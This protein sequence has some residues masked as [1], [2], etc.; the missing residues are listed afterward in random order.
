LLIDE[1]ATPHWLEKFSLFYGN[2]KFFAMFYTKLPLDTIL[3]KLS[4][5]LTMKLCLFTFILILSPNQLLRLSS[6]LVI[7][8]IPSK[9]S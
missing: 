5:A 8:D 9:I 7:G 6:G 1:I 3:Y 4:I 2:T